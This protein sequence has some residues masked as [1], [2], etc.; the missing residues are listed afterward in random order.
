M[1]RASHLPY[2]QNLLRNIT[3]T[4]G[5]CNPC[6]TD[7]AVLPCCSPSHE[8]PS[9]LWLPARLGVHHVHLCC[10]LRGSAEGAE[11]VGDSNCQ[12]SIQRRCDICFALRAKCDRADHT[13]RDN[14]ACCLVSHDPDFPAQ[15]QMRWKCS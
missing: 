4:I 3:Y 8:E 1:G 6:E 7:L 10:S 12:G 2:V 13:A 15:A 14:A 9:G 5:W 11:P